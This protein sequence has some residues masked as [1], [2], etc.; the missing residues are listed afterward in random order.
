[1][2]LIS[3]FARRYGVKVAGAGR[4]PLHSDIYNLGTCPGRNHAEISCRGF[5]SSC[6]GWCFKACNGRQLTPAGGR[7][8]TAYCGEQGRRTA[9]RTGTGRTLEKQE[10]RINELH[11]TIHLW[12]LYNNGTIDWQEYFPL[13]IDGMFISADPVAFN[14]DYY[15]EEAVRRVSNFYPLLRGAGM[16]EI[17]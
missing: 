9:G 13:S 8:C 1:M 3:P 10:R 15:V 6:S 7:G 17:F 16:P 12:L 11:A 4:P 2:A 14:F 5:F